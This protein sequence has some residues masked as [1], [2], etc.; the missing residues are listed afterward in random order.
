M[1]ELKRAL[2]HIIGGQDLTASQAQE[3][4][5][6]LM[7]G[8][9]GQATIGAF[10]ATLRL[11]G[12]TAE[13]IAGMA[14][15]MREAA[16]TIEPDVE[17][18]TDTCG[19]GGD[20]RGTFNISTTAALIACGAGLKVAK[21]GNRGVSSRCGSADVL[22]QLGV[23]IELEPERVR[24]CIERV[25]MGFLFAPLFH[26]AMRHVMPA[27]RDLGIPTIFNYLGPLA[28]PA[29]AP[30]QLLGVSGDGMAGRL[31]EVLAQLGCERALVIQGSDG[32]DEA[33][34]CGTTTIHRVE[35]ERVTSDELDPRELGLEPASEEDLR[36]G[37][38]AANA[39]I[40]L[41]VLE[42]A[43]GPKREVACLNAGLALLAGGLAKSAAQ[44]L[45]MARASIDSGAA[46]GRLEAL[47][48][49]TQEATA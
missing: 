13:E 20:R 17:G 34:L 44:G 39:A 25:G 48:R 5:G 19:T 23:R 27:R 24:E 1:Q 7:S 4:M 8:E 14:R 12:E 9:A 42:G 2:E 10:L 15:G 31:A 28:N 40:T 30:R 21:H 35:E 16:V 43:P 32:M 29:R 46:W 38:P 33:T 47:R 3:V 36:G 37:D 41:A 45:E 6:V 26:P 49:F 11:K 18:L 22:E